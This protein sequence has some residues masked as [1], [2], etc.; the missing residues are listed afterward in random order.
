MCHLRLFCVEILITVLRWNDLIITMAK[1]V[2]LYTINIDAM[3]IP[4]KLG[5]IGS[6]WISH[7]VNIR[8]QGQ[9]KK[10]KSWGPFLELPARQHYLKNGP[11][12]P[13]WR[14]CLAGSSKTASRIS[15]FFNCPG[16]RIFILCEIHCFLCPKKVNII[17]HS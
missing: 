11:N 17:I 4:K 14:C 7:Q 5:G 16:W 10:L 13:N 6:K 15:I 1:T 8:H 3:I 2:L 12:W 9:L